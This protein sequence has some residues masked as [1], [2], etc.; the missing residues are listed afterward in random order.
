VIDL[1][2]VQRF[3]LESTLEQLDRLLSEVSYNVGKEFLLSAKEAILA[4]LARREE[5]K[6]K[7][8]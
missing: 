2:E 4:E 1:R 3:K 5:H 8:N 7:I 6:T